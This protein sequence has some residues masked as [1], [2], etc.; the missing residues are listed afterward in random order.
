[1][2]IAAPMPVRPPFFQ[3]EV[4]WKVRKLTEHNGK[5]QRHAVAINVGAC[6]RQAEG[7]SQ[8]LEVCR[9]ELRVPS[10]V[11]VVPLH[12]S[13]IEVTNTSTLP[14][15]GRAAPQQKEDIAVRGALL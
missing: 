2:I 6:K 4:A 13:L 8:R 3:G 1:M 11:C 15:S 14:W 12:V 7:L 10:D 5:V 9:R